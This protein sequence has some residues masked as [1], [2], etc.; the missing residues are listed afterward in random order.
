MM[1]RFDNTYC[2]SCGGEFAPGDNGYSHCDQHKGLKNLDQAQRDPVGGDAGSSFLHGRRAEQAEA[3]C[4][5]L[6]Q[7]RTEVDRALAQQWGRAE[8]AEALAKL[9]KSQRDT[10][11]DRAEQAERERDRLIEDRARFPHRPDDVGRMIEAHIGNLKIGKT[12]AERHARD[13]MLKVSV[14]ITRLRAALKECADGLAEYVEHHYDRTKDHPAM[15]RRYDRDMQ[16]VIDARKLLGV[17]EQSE[18][19]EG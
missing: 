11:C 15:K 19:Q 5:R 17:H 4:L 3:D 6:N 16:P 9:F 8:Q 14:E 1:A 7:E 18:R 13:H 2:S 12:E 10:E